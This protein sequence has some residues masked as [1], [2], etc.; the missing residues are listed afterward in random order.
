MRGMQRGTG[1][2]LNGGKFCPRPIPCVVDYRRWALCI[3]HPALA[4]RRGADPFY[5]D[6]EGLWLRL[7]AWFCT[8]Y[9]YFPQNAWYTNIPRAS[10]LAFPCPCTP[11]AEAKTRPPPSTDALHGMAHDQMHCGDRTMPRTRVYGRHPAIPGPPPM[12]TAQH[13]IRPQRPQN[14]PAHRPPPDKHFPSIHSASIPFHALV[15]PCFG[16]REIATSSRCVAKAAKPPKT[17]PPSL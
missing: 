15:R 3:A 17:P 11:K 1:Y 7:T 9:R 10:I 4:T 16:A 6:S 12:P 8:W 2:S 5:R 14:G 13:F